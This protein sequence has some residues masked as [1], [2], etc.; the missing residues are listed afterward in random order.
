MLPR[1]V[2]TDLDGTLLGED[3]A[4]SARTHAALCA[5]HA[6][7]AVVVL[8]T[9]RPPR[10]VTELAAALPCH[11]VVICAN[12]AL[13]YDA[14]AGTVIAQQAIAPAQAAELLA[15]LRQALP[16]CAFAV[17]H[18][19]GFSHEA[20]YVPRFPTAPEAVAASAEELVT[21]PVAKLLARHSGSLDE[22]LLARCREAAAGLGEVSVSGAD[23]LLEIA[24]PG[25]T[26]AVALEAVARKLGVA[27]EETI[28]FGDMP[29]DIPMLAWAGWAVAVDNAHPEVKAVADEV[30]AACGADGVARVLERLLAAHAPAP[31]SRPQ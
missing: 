12:G 2:A 16:D 19:G 21:K 22:V 6:A 9:A 5:M 14:H 26:K 31:A 8:V 24:A 28:A 15:R 3:G 4:V 25:V 7:G 10:W 13:L 30:T 20:R 29:N 23:G 18:A 11:E 1:L 27:P 17:E